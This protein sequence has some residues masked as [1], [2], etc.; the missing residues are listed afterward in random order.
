MPSGD[1]QDGSKSKRYV[2]QLTNETR[3]A[4]YLK[5]YQAADI[6]RRREKLAEKLFREEQELQQELL[7]KQASTTDSSAGCATPSA[8]LL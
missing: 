8:L 7:E 5:A 6:N 3:R 2:L 1:A 4:E